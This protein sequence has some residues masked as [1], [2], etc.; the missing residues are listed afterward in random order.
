MAISIIG[1][2]I[3]SAEKIIRKFNNIRVRIGFSGEY[4]Q[5]Y[6]YDF[7]PLWLK[8]LNVKYLY[9]AKRKEEQVLF[10]TVEN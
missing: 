9:V 5:Y 7:F 8:I 4:V 10:L 2:S 6:G 1:Q 3:L